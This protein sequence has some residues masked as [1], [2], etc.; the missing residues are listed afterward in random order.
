[1]IGVSGRTEAMPVALV[2][3][4]HG[5]GS[6]CRHARRERDDFVHLQE[7]RRDDEF[8]RARQDDRL[9]VLRLAVR[10]RAPERPEYPTAR[11]AAPL[12]RARYPGAAN[13][14]HLARDWLLPAARPDTAR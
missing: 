1:M 8:Q 2:R 12:Q 5:D 10:D 13:L 9:P 11:G 4:R 6:E 3:S 7:L 14:P